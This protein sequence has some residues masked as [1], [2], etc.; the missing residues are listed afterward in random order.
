MKRLAKYMRDFVTQ[1]R[2]MVERQL[3]ARGIHDERVLEAMQTVPR[4]LFVPVTLQN[5]AYED[6]PLPIG[7]NQT[8]SQPYMVASMTQ[9]LELHGGERVL[10]IGT[11]SG[12]QTAVLAGLC[13]KVYSVER[14]A[15]LAERARQILHQ[16]GVSNVDIRVG[17]GTLGWPEHAPYDAILVTA[18]GSR[19]PPD[20][21]EQL[22]DG[23]HLVIPL[24][25]EEAH[26]LYRITRKAGQ[27]ISEPIE[28]CTFVP[29][30]GQYGIGS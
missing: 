2:Q 29:L 19:I 7:E 20:Y 6:G 5:R 8:I 1:R 23:G 12:Y 25:H 27:W 11:G 9:L 17:D 22:G 30:V 14:H 13:R 21:K 15:E 4:E 18:G 24:E 26:L 28:R 10:E 3:R 16:I